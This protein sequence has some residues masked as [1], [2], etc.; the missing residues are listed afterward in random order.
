MKKESDKV[1]DLIIESLSVM[2]K[3]FKINDS[4]SIQQLRSEVENLYSASQIEISTI[5]NSLKDGRELNESQHMVL[6]DRAAEVL[7]N[8]RADGVGL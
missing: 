6:L 2:E 3:F 8:R 7:K 5:R 1:Q 4:S